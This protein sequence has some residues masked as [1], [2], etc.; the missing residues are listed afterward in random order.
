MQANTN[1]TPK[2]NSWRQNSVVQ[3]HSPNFLEPMR[4]ARKF[5]T[6]SSESHWKPKCEFS[7]ILAG[8]HRVH[9]RESERGWANHEQ[10]HSSLPSPERRTS[11]RWL[12]MQSRR[13]VREESADSAGYLQTFGQ[14]EGRI[15]KKNARKP[16]ELSADKSLLIDLI[17]SVC[18]K[19]RRNPLIN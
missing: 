17:A 18:P 14:N 1:R 10:S 12:K 2:H 9:L 4:K 11:V 6:Q 16:A 13:L 15:S 5:L 7:C 8:G 3:R 19:K